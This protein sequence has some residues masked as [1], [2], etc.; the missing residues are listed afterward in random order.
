MDSET[1][2]RLSASMKEND[3]LP[4]WMVTL[5]QPFLL[6]SFRGLKIEI[7]DAIENLYHS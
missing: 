4:A 5:M 7:T 2:G 1:G 3:G 6:T